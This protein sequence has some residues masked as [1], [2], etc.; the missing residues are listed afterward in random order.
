MNIGLLISQ[1]L[2]PLRL[3]DSLEAKILRAETGYKRKFGRQ[4]D[5]VHINAAEFKDSGI[6]QVG[7]IRVVPSQYI[8]RGDLWIGIEGDA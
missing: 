4:P 1:G 5:M 7:R 8:S 2:N 6:T 3:T